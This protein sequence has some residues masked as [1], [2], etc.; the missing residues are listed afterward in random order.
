MTKKIKIDQELYD[1]LKDAMS[2]Q[3]II[4]KLI[5]ENKELK[6]SMYKY[7]SQYHQIAQE[8]KELYYENAY[9][10]KMFEETEDTQ[11]I[12]YNDKLFMIRSIVHYQAQGEPETVNIDA[13]YSNIKVEVN[14][15]G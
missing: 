14:E 15:D 3:R 10:K 2:N 6:E 8:N 12:K 4:D 1:K 7:Q 11:A 5:E 13:E 9:L